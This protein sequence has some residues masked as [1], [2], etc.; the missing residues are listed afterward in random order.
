MPN[1]PSRVTRTGRTRGRS[2]AET[3]ADAH[4][5]KAGRGGDKF[6]VRTTFSV[7]VGYRFGRGPPPCFVMVSSPG[8]PLWGARTA[9]ARPRVSGA[10]TADVRK[11]TKRRR[12]DFKH[13][14]PHLIEAVDHEHARQRETLTSSG[15]VSMAT[16]SCC[17]PLIAKI[18]R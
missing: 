13:F 18:R 4:P 6:E 2:V 3:R 15:F 1:D 9:L 14:T 5:A 10:S 12:T 8:S 7:L 11:F 17:L 16:R